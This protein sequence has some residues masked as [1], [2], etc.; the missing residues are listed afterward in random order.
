MYL[1][2]MPCGNLE[3]QH[4]RRSFSYDEC[5]TILYQS[6]SALEYL[7]GLT[8]AHRDIKPENILVKYR[9]REHLC[10]KLTDSGLSKTG[11]L[12]TFYGSGSYCPPEIQLDKVQLKYTRAVDIWSLDVVILR[13]AYGLPGPG[14]GFGTQWCKEIVGKANDCKSKGLID[15]L[16]RM[17]VI[18]AELRCS[19]RT[20]CH[21]ALRRVPSS[22]DR[23][24]TPTQASY[25]AGYRETM[26]HPPPEQE[27]LR[28]LAHKVRSRT[29]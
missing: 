1:E 9:D 10:I 29:T 25:S 14:Y 4:C 15:I 19:A 7:H 8:V 5:L 27:T 11:I 21:E 23:S 13:F 28:I 18:E 17:L 22:R 3:N 20:C 12:K 6:S 16:R 26:V 2:Y 24:A